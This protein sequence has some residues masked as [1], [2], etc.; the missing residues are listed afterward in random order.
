M[1]D[2]QTRFQD[3]SRIGSGDNKDQARGFTD[4]PSPI[5]GRIHRG[6]P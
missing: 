6:R 4:M 3:E 2:F 1:P 5:P